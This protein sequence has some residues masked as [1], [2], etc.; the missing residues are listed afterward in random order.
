[1]D[2]RPPI[3][4][5]NWWKMFYKGSYANFRVCVATF[6]SVKLAGKPHIW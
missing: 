3:C 5:V 4:R 1:M 2:P 6:D